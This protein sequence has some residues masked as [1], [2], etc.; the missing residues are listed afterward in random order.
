MKHDVSKAGSKFEERAIAVNNPG[1][2]TTLNLGLGAGIGHW[3]Q[4]LTRHVIY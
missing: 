3:S 1:A 2:L 4:L